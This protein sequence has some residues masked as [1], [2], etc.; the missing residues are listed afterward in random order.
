MLNFFID[1]ATGNLIVPRPVEL[2]PQEALE[3][4]SRIE[5]TYWRAHKSNQQRESRT[6]YE[7]ISGSEE[8]V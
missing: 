8:S 1:E 5:A 4:A 3:F 2:T 7:T 6:V